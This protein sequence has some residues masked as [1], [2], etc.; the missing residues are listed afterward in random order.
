MV[1]PGSGELT[2][3]YSF[4]AILPALVASQPASMSS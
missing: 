1:S 2:V 4:G 3:A